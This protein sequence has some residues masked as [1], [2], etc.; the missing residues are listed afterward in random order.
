MS[1]GTALLVIDTQVAMF[2][3]PAF[4]P[5]ASDAMIANIRGLIDRARESG[6]EV[7]YVRHDDTSYE[8]MS[9]G[10]PGWEIVPEISPN[11]GERVFDKRAC[12]S[13]YATGLADHLAAIGVT[14]LVIAGMQTEMCI[15]TACRSALHR[16]FNVTLASDAHSTWDGESVTAEQIIAH[17]NRTLAGIPHPANR[18]TVLPSAEIAF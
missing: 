7:L 11:P 16:D 15:D 1:D 17:H 8:P 9:K 6:V 5:F 4:M 13:F 12:D 2:A 3:D 10:A 18:I 14:H